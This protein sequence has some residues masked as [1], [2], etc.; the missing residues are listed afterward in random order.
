MVEIRRIEES[1]AKPLN[2]SSIQREKESVEVE[3]Y[4]N[5]RVLNERGDLLGRSPGDW[6]SE[7]GG[8]E[9]S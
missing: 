9:E 2:T 3:N 5:R 6:L 8:N 1:S 7:Q 4:D